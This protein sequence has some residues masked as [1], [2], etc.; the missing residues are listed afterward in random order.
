MYAMA[1]PNER[2]PHVF[3]FTSFNKKSSILTRVEGERELNGGITEE[4]ESH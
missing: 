4:E 1:E 2:P 3:V